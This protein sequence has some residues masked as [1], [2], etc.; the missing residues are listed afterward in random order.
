MNDNNTEVIISV[1]YY[2]LISLLCR[3]I[4]LPNRFQSKSRA[5]EIVIEKCISA[6]VYVAV[7]AAKR[8]PEPKL[9]RH[10]LYRCVGRGP[11]CVRLPTGVGVWTDAHVAWVMMITNYDII[12]IAKN[13]AEHEEPSVSQKKK[14]VFETTRY[15]IIDLMTVKIST[16]SDRSQRLPTRYFSIRKTRETTIKFIRLIRLRRCILCILCLGSPE[17]TD[18]KSRLVWFVFIA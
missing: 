3:R 6:V 4:R 7:A 10:A 5:R 17:K 8:W 9:R 16:V 15:P 14:H 12:T 13:S 11:V 18:W 1:I 2:C